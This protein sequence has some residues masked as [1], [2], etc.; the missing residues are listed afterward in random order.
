MLYMTGHEGFRLS[1]EEV[2]GLREYLKKGGLL[3]AEACC[4]RRAFGESLVRELRRVLPGHVLSPVPANSPL[5]SMPNVVRE[6]GV[7]PAL[8]A[9]LGNRPMVSPELQAIEMDGHYS[10]IFSPYGLAGGWELSPNPYAHG[11][12][13]AGSLALGENICMYAITQ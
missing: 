10:V 8:A 7:T 12:D 5:F 1:D 6:V 11:Y 3:F 13:N 2:N 9:H 4:G